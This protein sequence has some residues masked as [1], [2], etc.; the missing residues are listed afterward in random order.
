MQRINDTVLSVREL[1]STLYNS[2]EER[3][4]YFKFGL[5]KA[6]EKTGFAVDPKYIEKIAPLATRAGLEAGLAEVKEV[7][8]PY[9]KLYSEGEYKAL[10]SEACTL[11]NDKVLQPV[12][13]SETAAPY[14][15]KG[16]ALKENLAPRVEK[17][18]D[19]A[20]PYIARGSELK[21]SVKETVAKAREDERVQKAMA[22]LKTKLSQVRERPADVVLELRSTAVDLIKYEK[23]AEYREYMLSAE[24]AADTSK[25]VKEDL[26]TLLKQDLPALVN[27]TAAAV[28]AELAHTRDVLAEAWK[29]GR[30]AT[31]EVRS[32]DDLRGLASVLVGEVQ[33]ALVARAD[34]LA[35]EKKLLD[36]LGRLKA[37]F[38]LEERA[39]PLEAKAVAVPTGEAIEIDDA[40]EEESLKEAEPPAEMP[41]LEAAEEEPPKVEEPATVEEP[42]EEPKEE[43]P[44]TDGKKKGKKAKKQDA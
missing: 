16:E 11:A 32:W 36:A 33:A 2:P 10:V 20:A 3:Q 38:G 5:E 39:P 4:E 25:L 41:Q 13:A 35:V 40:G 26:P 43:V 44:L 42:A 28:Q 9:L 6:V 1:S 8:A 23:V 31:P 22:A 12:L 34:D 14:L 27:T 24:F 21:D 15:A 18:R 7:A 29:K 17:V 19:V 37:V 30:E